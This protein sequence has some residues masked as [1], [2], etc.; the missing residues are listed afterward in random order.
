MKRK[1]FKELLRSVKKAAA[2]ERGE[3]KPAR[4]FK[5]RPAPT[6]ACTPNSSRL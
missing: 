6:P 5:R 4:V 3:A 2:I 1:F